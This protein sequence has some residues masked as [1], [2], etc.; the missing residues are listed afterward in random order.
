MI[1]VALVCAVVSA[2]AWTAP[3]DLRVLEWRAGLELSARH[4]GGRVRKRRRPP[5]IATQAVPSGP[6]SVATEAV[7]PSAMPNTERFVPSWPLW[8]ARIGGDGCRP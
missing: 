1:A 7:T 5:S 2:P 3:V 8:C 6:Q 4:R